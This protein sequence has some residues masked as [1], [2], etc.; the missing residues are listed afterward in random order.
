[1]NPYQVQFNARMDVAFFARHIL[2]YNL[3]KVHTQM[4]DL[5][6]NPKGVNQYVCVVAARGHL[7]T[8]LFSVVYPLWRMWREVNYEICMTSSSFDQTKKVLDII[9]SLMTTNEYL[10]PLVPDI[11]R[12]VVWNKNEIITSNGNKLYIKPFNDTI[13]G[14][15]VN[16]FINDD[17]LRS[18]DITQSE[19]KEKFWGLVYPCVQTKKGQIIVVGTPMTT[20]DL[21]ADLSGSD[22]ETNEPLHPDWK[23][24]RFPACDL[25][26]D[27]KLETPIWTEN[28]TLEQLENIRKSQGALIFDREYLLNPISGGSALFPSEMLRRQLWRPPILNKGRKKCHYYIGVDISLTQ[29]N[30]SDW[31]VI[32]LIEK[33]ENDV[34]RLITFERFKT[35]NSA[36]IMRRIKHYA[37]NFNARKV[38]I[39]DR[40]LSQG[41]C[42]EMKNDKDIGLLIESFKTGK[43]NKE[44][45]VSHLQSGFQAGVLFIPENPV[46][47][48][49]LRRFGVKKDRMGKQTYEALGG[50][51][52]V[53]VGLCLAFEAATTLKKGSAGIDFVDM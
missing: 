50:H 24:A 4:L 51:D 27:G 10:L 39:E 33:D 3:G 53:V 34:C 49:E 11:S 15:H 28:F 32:A 8:T 37:V 18:E 48:D 43:T 5:I 13:R 21:L 40:G 6:F 52:D 12:S 35:S 38:M 26:S 2:G 31:T 14:T 19:I 45:L 36:E 7:K 25:S 46:L 41:I 30:A 22:P 17:I 47:L 42:V 29:D 20:D 44:E 9:K 1:M 16:L 23:C